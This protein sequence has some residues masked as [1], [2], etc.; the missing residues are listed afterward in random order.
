MGMLQ[1]HGIRIAL[2]SVG[3]FVR[4]NKFNMLKS[5]VM[6]GR[7]LALGGRRFMI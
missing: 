3:S 7:E 2:A 1:V 6:G 4:A 5:R